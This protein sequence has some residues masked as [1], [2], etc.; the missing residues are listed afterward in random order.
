ML[1]VARAR[2][3]LGARAPEDD[4][5]LQAMVDAVNRLSEVA[6]SMAER[7]VEE[8]REGRHLHARVN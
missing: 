6:V 7:I 8:K 5:A 1:T 4:V 2:E 3:I